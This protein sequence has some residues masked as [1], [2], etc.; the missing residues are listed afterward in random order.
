MWVFLLPGLEGSDLHLFFFHLFFIFLSSFWVEGFFLSCSLCMKLME[1][2]KFMSDDG[3]DLSGVFFSCFF[4]FVLAIGF[5]LHLLLYIVMNFF[6]L[7]DEF[8]LF[9]T[10]MTRKT[11][12]VSC[13][14]IYMHVR[15]TIIF[16]LALVVHDS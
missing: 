11:N 3:R 4:C 2:M 9:E 5:H 1:L 8:L 15:N 7:N 6:Q 14:H 13:I 12:N 16:V 10:G